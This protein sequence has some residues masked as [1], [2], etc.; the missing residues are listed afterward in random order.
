M[1]E[2]APKKQPSFQIGQDLSDLSVDELHKYAETLRTE[3]IRLK[4]AATA[5][6][7]SL[8]AADAFF[9]T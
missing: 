5:K 2:D 6:T 7:A 8:S 4:E 9:R 1:T 3:I